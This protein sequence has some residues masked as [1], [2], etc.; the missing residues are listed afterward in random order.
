LEE[1]KVF[2]AYVELPD[3]Y[4]VQLMVLRDFPGG[5]AKRGLR[6]NIFRSRV[7]IGHTEE[8]EPLVYRSQEHPDMSIAVDACY[9]ILLATARSA[10][11]SPAA[12]EA[13]QQHVHQYF[14]GTKVPD[15]T[16]QAL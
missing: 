14:G 7:W 5:R 1:A 13:I 8:P 3:G 4:E 9:S 6:M 10:V 15:G 12:L 2:D 11:N 16:T